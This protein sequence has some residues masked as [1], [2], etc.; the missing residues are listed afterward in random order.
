MVQSLVKR[1][2]AKGI[3]GDWQAQASAVVEKAIYPAL[4]EQITAIES[5]R[6]RTAAGDGV[7]RTPRGD[8]IYAAALKQATTTDLSADQIH[9]MGLE[10]VADISA[11]LDGIL[12]DAGYSSGTVGERLAKLNVEP[13]QLYAD[14]TEIRNDVDDPID[15]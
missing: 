8:E 3:T 2:A 5:L 4:D 12:K 14:S 6:A 10:Q 7:W 1:A 15:Q 13:S 9:A 11:Q